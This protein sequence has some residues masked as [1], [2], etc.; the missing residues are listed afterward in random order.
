MKWLGICLLVLLG[1]LLLLLLCPIG[2]RI[3]ASDHSLSADVRVFGIYFRVFPFRRKKTAGKAKG[4][5]ETTAADKTEQ[6]AARQEVSGPSASRQTDEPEKA[7]E[8]A[9]K[10]KKKSF[11]ED[12]TF[13]RIC[14]LLGF[15]AQAV[16]RVLRA[17]YVPQFQLCAR[18]HAD[19]AAKT[20]LM[21]GGACSFMGAVMPQLRRVFRIRKE[22]VRL[23]PD[24]EGQTAFTLSVTVM[25]VPLQLV[26]LALILL[27]QWYKLNKKTKA[28]QK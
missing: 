9:D 18:L 8:P 20:A 5:A 14:R 21:Y 13:E 22:D 3:K 17:F 6:P 25:T 1:L 12:L 11:V 16:R 26:V 23:W 10:P 24:F 2:V 27:F 4:S 19:D 7:A 15:A 28:V